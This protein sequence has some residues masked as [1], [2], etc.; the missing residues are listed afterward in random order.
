MG[1]GGSKPAPQPAVVEQPPPAG[2]EKANIV[3][4]FSEAE[5]RL[6]GLSRALA[7][8]CAGCTLRITAGLSGSSVKITRQ[9]GTASI[10][11]CSSYARD[12]QMTKDKKMSWMDFMSNLEAGAYMRDLGNGYCEEI[13]VSPEDSMKVKN[14]GEYKE[15]IIKTV[16]IR[17]QGF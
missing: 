12:L 11:Q 1:G 17:K 14:G 4:S 8:D 2:S 13:R 10:R 3:Y 15:D 16:R 5:P 7:N 6:D 9:F